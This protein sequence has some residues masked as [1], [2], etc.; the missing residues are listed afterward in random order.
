MR[1]SRSTAITE[2]VERRVAGFIPMP[3]LPNEV[4][5]DAAKQRDSPMERMERARQGGLSAD[6]GEGDADDRAAAPLE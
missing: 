3:R 1:T 6:I 5:D 4:P 2:S